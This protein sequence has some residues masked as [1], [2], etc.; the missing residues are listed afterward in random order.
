MVSDLFEDASDVGAFVA[1]SFGKVARSAA[2]ALANEP[3]R[4]GLAAALPGLVFDNSAA[5]SAAVASLRSGAD[6]S[7]SAM[8]PLGVHAA[9]AAA[10]SAAAAAARAAR[11]A[12]LLAT[13]K[14]VHAACARNEVSALPR[15]AVMESHVGQRLWLEGQRREHGA[16]GAHG[17]HHGVPS[18][19]AVRCGRHGW[20]AA[21][22]EGRM[23]LWRAG[24]RIMVAGLALF[25]ALCS[26]RGDGGG[27]RHRLQNHRE[28]RLR[29]A[30][31]AARASEP[32][33]QGR[34]DQG[35]HAKAQG[36][37]VDPVMQ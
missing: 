1:S 27:R 34:R 9:A 22:P 7:A 30:P 14:E 33:A 11:R 12:A 36:S 19:R 24:A 3:S 5:G 15:D 13:L 23:L 29:D 2:D 16:H 25:G 21:L 28:G 4:A 37:T 10:S 18:G 6:G 17:A 32:A 31:V 35:S 8:A 26:A 20:P